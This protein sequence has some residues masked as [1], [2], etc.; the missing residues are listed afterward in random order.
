LTNFD[1]LFDQMFDCFTLCL[2]DGYAVVSSD[3][4]GEYVVVGE[5]RA[6]CMQ[7]DLALK[8]GQVAYITTGGS[9]KSR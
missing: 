4:P 9:Q 2:Q 7:Q 1:R 3:G 6:G 5:A 8:P